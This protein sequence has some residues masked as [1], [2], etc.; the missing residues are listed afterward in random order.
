MFLPGWIGSPDVNYASNSIYLE[1]YPSTKELFA[2][3]G[4]DYEVFENIHIMPNLW[5]NHYK[6]KDINGNPVPKNGVDLA[7]RV[8]VYYRFNK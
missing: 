8:T 5:L 4:V 6:S 3:V 1:D 7:G 2:T